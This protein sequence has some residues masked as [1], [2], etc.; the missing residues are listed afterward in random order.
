MVSSTLRFGTR[1]WGKT[2]EWLGRSLLIS[3]LRLRGQQ[4]R[5]RVG[6]PKREKR[7]GWRPC[8]RRMGKDPSSLAQW[9]LRRWIFLPMS[10]R[11]N[12]SLS[13]PRPEANGRGRR[14][15]NHNRVRVED[16][17][18]PDEPG[19]KVA[20][21]VV[22]GLVALAVGWPEAPVQALQGFLCAGVGVLMVV[23]PPRVRVGWG[24]VAAAVAFVVLACGV[25]LPAGWLRLP[26]WRTD[27]EA[28]GVATGPLVTAH[29][30]VAA[31]TL[32]GFAVTAA[33]VVFLLGHRVSQRTHRALALCFVFGVAAYAAVSIA[34]Q[35]AAGAGAQPAGHFGLFPNRNH[36]ATLLV[37]GVLTGIGSLLQAIRG[38]QAVAIVLSLVP[39]VFCLAVLLGYSQSRAGVVLLVV[40]FVGGLVLTGRGYFDRHTAR[41]VWLMSGAVVLA[42]VFLETGA[43]SRLS[44]TV[45]KLSAEGG[46]VEAAGGLLGQGGAK[47]AI[48]PGEAVDLRVPIH[49]DA[50]SMIAAEPWPGVGAGQFRYVFPQHQVRSAAASGSLCLHPESDWLLMAAETGVAA[51]VAVV[52]GVVMLAWAAFGAARRGRG[53]ALRVG[54]TLAALVVP[55]HGVIDVPGHRVGLAWAAAWLMGLV[56]RPPVD[57]VRRAW[58]WPWRVVGLA[59]LAGGGWLIWAEWFG[60]PALASVRVAR[61]LATVKQLYAADRADVARAQA[62]GKVFQPAPGEPDR[63]ELA[64]GEVDK[65]I[66]LTPLDG[67]LHHTRAALGLHFDDK[68]DMVDKAFAAERRLDPGW[69]DLPVRQAAAWL[70]TDAARADRLFEDALRRAAAM[71]R[72]FPGTRFSVEATLKKISAAR[73]AAAKEKLKAES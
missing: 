17:D 72:S 31:E 22:L 21:G 59:V 36:T 71:D 14:N 8:D 55:L 60:G 57:E 47:Q 9:P 40:G 2:E 37:M 64:L 34:V 58:G 13:Q 38:K 43:M 11:V 30:R 24:W 51:T 68:D 15:H 29:P 3:S 19:A 54:C 4:G 62:E 48:E 42:L 12:E 32:G 26:G 63:L 46:P 7:C 56:F 67:D 44:A 23:W 6:L 18:L 39:M 1:G 45:D 20:Y 50:L 25:F 73:A 53:R 66:A 5:A 52:A 35:G 28:L 27:L 16:R 33:V 61:H 65:A 10:E 49:R 69:V 70:G 41:A